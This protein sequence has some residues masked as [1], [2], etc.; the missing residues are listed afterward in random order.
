MSTKYS[1]YIILRRNMVPSEMDINNVFSKDTM[2][3]IKSVIFRPIVETI[4]KVT[5][6]TST[7][8]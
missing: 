4:L 7:I 3:Q 8:M 2:D 5:I 1:Q 6:T